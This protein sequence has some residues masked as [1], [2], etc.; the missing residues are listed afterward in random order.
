MQNLTFQSINREFYE[1]YKS[2]PEV[3]SWATF[4]PNI[5]DEEMLRKKKLITP[6]KNQKLC[7]CCWAVSV[8]TSISDAFIVKGLVDWSPDVSYT[9]A[10]SKYPQEQCNG[11]NGRDL[12][13]RIRDGDGVSTE[14]CV[15]DSWN[16]SS[17]RV[18]RNEFKTP[19]EYKKILSKKI[20]KEGCYGKGMKHYVY[21]IDEVYPMS[22]RDPLKIS[23]V[24]ESMKQHIMI[25]GPLIASFLVTER[26]TKGDFGEIYI[27]NQNLDDLKI[28]G[29]HSTVILGWGIEENVKVNGKYLNV[30]YWH[31]RNSWG[32]E[33]NQNGFFKCAMYPYNKVSQFE[34][35]IQATFGNKIYE[36][37]GVTGFNVLYPP[38]LK[39]LR[40]NNVKLKSNFKKKGIFYTLDENKIHGKL[41]IDD[42]KNN[43]WSPYFNAVPIFI[44]G[45]LF[46]RNYSRDE[47][48]KD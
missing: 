41:V 47:S 37:D 10:M 42:L 29:T 32:M 45:Y 40:Y 26:F 14:Y 4:N 19:A 28:T 2:I 39:K 6:V 24:Q 33:W 35:I 3:F 12:L 48:I 9:Y 15:D 18:R 46:Y 16:I 43:N 21:R 1:K 13:Y 36:I 7:G 34:K 20:P 5:D 11:G 25:R 17:S 38:N 44:L 27:E 23:Q 8:A 30:P 31:C 22:T